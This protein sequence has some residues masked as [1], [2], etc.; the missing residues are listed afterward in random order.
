MNQ[1]EKRETNTNWVSTQHDICSEWN[2]NRT[3]CVILFSRWLHW[4]RCTKKKKKQTSNTKRIFLKLPEKRPRIR[5]KQL[6]FAAILASNFKL[7]QI[8][9]SYSSHWYHFYLSLLSPRCSFGKTVKRTVM[10]KFRYD[11]IP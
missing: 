4:S 7:I 5:K 9:S 11:S 2:I 8:S 10:L 3:A 1:F 6:L